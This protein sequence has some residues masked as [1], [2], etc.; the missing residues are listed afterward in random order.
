YVKFLKAHP[1]YDVM[2]TSTKLVI[3]DTQLS[4]KK[5]FHA[6]NDNRIHAAPLWDTTKQDF[7]GLLTITHFIQVLLRCYKDNMILANPQQQ[8]Q[9]QQLQQQQQ[10]PTFMT[11][12]EPKDSMYD[13]VMRLLSNKIHRVPIVDT[14][15]GNILYMLTL[16]RILRY[17]YLFFSHYNL[18]HPS[19]MKQTLAETNIGTYQNLAMI[20]TGSKLIEALEMM[21]ERRVSALPIVD[22]GMKLVGMFNKSLLMCLESEEAYADLDIPI[23]LI[24]NEKV[25]ITLEMTKTCMKCERMDVIIERMVKGEVHRLV[26]VDVFGRVDGILSC[27]DVMK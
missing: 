4:V 21:M 18:P 25:G 27:S 13:V 6:L 2:P 8:Q 9:Q 17:L 24:F 23:G 11:Y 15:A 16:K 22:E 12:S 10:Q 1:C 5:A 20:R 26:V 3:L 19:F 7:I 14:L